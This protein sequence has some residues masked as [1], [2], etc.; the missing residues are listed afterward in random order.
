[1]S[2]NVI[3]FNENNSV[4]EKVGNKRLQAADFIL[5]TSTELISIAAAAEL[6]TLRY[7]LK[8]VELEASI[9]KRTN[10]SGTPPRR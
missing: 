7:L 10:Q 8:L 6:E 5:T 2:P 3:D 9:C 4:E 1:M